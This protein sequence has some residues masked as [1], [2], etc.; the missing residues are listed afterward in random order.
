MSFAETVYARARGSLD[1]EYGQA[2]E[3]ARR[4]SL[5]WTAPEPRGSSLKSSFPSPSSPRLS[6]ITL[7]QGA[8]D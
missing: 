2:T 7:M 1:R 3:L 8:V 5:M 4:K 6:S